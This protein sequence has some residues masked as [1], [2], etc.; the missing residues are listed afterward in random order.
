M[1][2]LVV[3]LGNPGKEYA[4]TRHNVGARVLETVRGELAGAG[5]GF[6]D[7]RRNDEFRAAVSEGRLGGTKVVL[8]LPQTYM[9]ESGAAVQPAARF[10]KVEPAEVLVVYDDKDLPLGKLRIRAG[11]SAGGHNGMRSVIE[12][13]GTEDLPRLRVGIGASGGSRIADAAK[14]VLGKFAPGERDKI[15]AAEKRA[16]EA[17]GAILKDGLE[18]A[19]NK[20]NE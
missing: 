18:A 12:R 16:A 3:G 6:D 17:V 2:K 14:F 1:I 5:G 19:M 9:N 11:G 13:M 15:A 10:W 8:M 4:N 7:F 20:Y